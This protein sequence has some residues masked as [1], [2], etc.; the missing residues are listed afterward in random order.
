MQ[1]KILVVD[2]NPVF[3]KLMDR[4]LSKEGHQAVL[5]SSGLEAFQALKSFTPEIIFLDLIM[6][7]I[8]GKKLC[9][10]IR[11]TP[12]YN[13]ITLVVISGAVTEDEESFNEYGADYCIA[14]GVFTRTAEHI[15]AI[16]NE[17]NSGKKGK[18]SNMVLG[19][20]ETHQPTQITKELIHEKEHLEFILANISTGI[21]ELNEELEIIYCNEFFQSLCGKGETELLAKR[22]DALFQEEEKALL[23]KEFQGA[24]GE[25]NSGRAVPVDLQGEKLWVKV[26]PVVNDGEKLFIVTIHKKESC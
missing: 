9:Q 8:D 25:Q 3:L 5:V 24:H 15:R 20:G 10:L 4:L 19:L 16:I 12:R 23:Q 18:L 1:N 2:N 26:K 14:K 21:A 6:P 17:V 22:F 7:H 13:Q 11:R